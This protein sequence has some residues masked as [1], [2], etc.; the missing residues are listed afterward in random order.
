MAIYLQE[1]QN[2]KYGRTIADSGGRPEQIDDIAKDHLVEAISTDVQV[3]DP[4]T[5]SQAERKVKDVVVES[6]IRRNL[7]CLTGSF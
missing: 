5:K 4:V 3:S 7:N 2:K 6:D 1:T